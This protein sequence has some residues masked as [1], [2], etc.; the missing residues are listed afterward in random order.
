MRQ[1]PWSKELARFI[2]PQCR[3]IASDGR[4][5]ALESAGNSPLL[6]CVVEDRPRRRLLI[7][8]RAAAPQCPNFPDRRAGGI[9]FDERAAFHLPTK[10][11][12]SAICRRVVVLSRR[13][14]G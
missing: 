4:P 8:R 3:E 7:Q 10:D 6:T 5:A 13:I 14:K 11:D 1:P 9:P 12:L 2:V